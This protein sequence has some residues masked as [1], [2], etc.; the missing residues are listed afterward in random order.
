MPEMSILEA[1]N[2]TLHE[3]MERDDRVLMFGQ[4]VAVNGGQNR[5]YGLEPSALPR[6]LQHP[7]ALSVEP[8]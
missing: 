7:L 3:E 2:A 6:Q 8:G 5:R 4:D 1:I